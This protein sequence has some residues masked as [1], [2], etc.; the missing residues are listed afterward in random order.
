MAGRRYGPRAQSTYYRCPHDQANPRHA[1]ASPGHPPTVQAPEKVLDRIVGEFFDT[2]VFGPGRAALVAAQLPVTQAD[3]DAGRDATRHAL[4][5]RLKQNETAKKAQI[6]AHEHL[7]EEDPGT[8]AE[9]RTRIF[10]RFAELRAEREQLQAQLDALDTTTAQPADI[11]LLDQLPLTANPLPRLTPQ[12]KALLFQALN[13][14]ILWNPADRQATVWV[15]ITDTTLRAI[16]AI[17]DPGHDGHH[18]TNPKHGPDQPAPTCDFDKPPRTGT[19]RHRPANHCPPARSI[20]KLPGQPTRWPRIPH[21]D[22]RQTGPTWAQATGRADWPANH[23]DDGPGRRIGDHA[24]AREIQ[25]W[26][27]LSPG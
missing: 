27:V 2:Y 19:M 21:G 3:A 20:A 9:M 12:L 6:T 4:N 22:R 16:P 7:P 10:D 25:L 26:A 17:L 8:A 13:L 5:L 23:G 24:G 1:A 18:D 11:T 14:E 15:E